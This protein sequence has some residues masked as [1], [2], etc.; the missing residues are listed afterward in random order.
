MAA[1]ADAGHSSAAIDLPGHGA[2]EGRGFRGV[3]DYAFYVARSS[4]ST[5]SGT[6]T[7]SPATVSAA[8]SPS[9]TPSTTPAPLDGL[10]LIDTGARLRV[11]PSILHNVY[12]AAAGEPTDAPADPRQGYAKATPDTVI[13]ELTRL[14]ADEDPRVTYLDWIADDSCD[15]LTRLSGIHIPALAICG[16]EDPL[17]PVKYH[18]H[19][20][21]HLP[22]CHLEIIPN[23][24]HWPYVEQP[25]LFDQALHAF[26]SRPT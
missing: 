23:A 17:T 9:P 3:A 2:S 19:F 10:I 24:G 22:D 16:A 26:L 21:R 4:P 5:S 25:Q 20:R 7:P 15:F 8:A 14:R 18:E 11:H 13:E 12:L 6:A 1:L